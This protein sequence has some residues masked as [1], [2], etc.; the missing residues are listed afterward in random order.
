MTSGEGLGAKDRERAINQMNDPLASQLPA[1]PL[2]S[3]AALKASAL[4][5]PLLC[6]HE[7]FT[8]HDLKWAT[9]MTCGYW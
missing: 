8:D 6:S 3:S 1:A 2:A 5:H 7:E 9:R 4:P